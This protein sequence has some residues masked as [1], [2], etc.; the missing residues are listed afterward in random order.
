M[1][2]DMIDRMPEKLSE[3]MPDTMPAKLSKGMPGRMQER[4][5]D[6]MPDGTASSRSYW[7]LPDLNC[8]LQISVDTAG[9]Q[10]GGGGR[11]GQL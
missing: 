10:P 8:E 4:M 11:G 1:S 2:E 5:S 9:P 6:D 3:D 7:A